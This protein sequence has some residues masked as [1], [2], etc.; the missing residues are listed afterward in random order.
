MAGDLELVAMLTQRDENA[1]AELDR[2]YGSYM[3]SVAYNVL[4]NVADSEECVNDALLRVWNS[5]PP[6]APD[7]LKPYLKEITRN[8]AIDRYR[9]THRKK[10]IPSESIVPLDELKEDPQDNSSGQ[11]EA[12]DTEISELIAAFLRTQS[13]RKIAVFVARYYHEETVEE[14]ARTLSLHK[15][16]VLS[17]LHRLR[18]GLAKFLEKEG[19]TP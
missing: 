2:A 19:V 4:K 16:T 7:N 9:L 15:N 1:I 3:R 6:A 8:V 12:Q 13:E 11:A 10:D 18:K 14:I 17:D 5:I